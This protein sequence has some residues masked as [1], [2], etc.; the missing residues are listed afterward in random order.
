[1]I[2]LTEKYLLVIGGEGE[3]E[4]LEEKDDDDLGSRDDVWVFSIELN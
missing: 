2:D 4:E 3:K 1:M